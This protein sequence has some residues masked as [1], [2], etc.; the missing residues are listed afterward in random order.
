MPQPP[1]CKE[2]NVPKLKHVCFSKFIGDTTLVRAI[3]PISERHQI[4]TL[5]RIHLPIV[6]DRPVQQSERR[7]RLRK[8]ISRHLNPRLERK[9]SC[10]ALSLRYRQLRSKK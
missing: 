10:T 6:P 4:R 1:L 9:A 5:E 8:E 3:R 2:G 7:G